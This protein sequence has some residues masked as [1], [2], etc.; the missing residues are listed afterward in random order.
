[1]TKHTMVTFQLHRK[2]VILIVI[3]CVFLAVLL[4]AVGYLAG[5]TRGRSSMKPAAA[6]PA[7]AAKTK[8]AT[9]APPAAPAPQENF[10]LRV[11]LVTSEAEAKEEVARLAIKK[12]TAT[13]IPV[14]RNESEVVYE[15]H[16]GRYPDRRAAV[17]AAQSLREHGVDSAVVP[18]P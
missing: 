8:P 11:G 16:V 14:E 10:S 5:V 13:V 7:V 6:A 2:G 12:L 18:A 9:A 3:G 15:I 17:E 4:V 1:M